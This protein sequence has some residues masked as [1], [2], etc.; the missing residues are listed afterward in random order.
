V[1]SLLAK[2]GRDTLLQVPG[3]ADRNDRVVLNAHKGI[4]IPVRNLD[5]AIIALKVRHDVG[6]NGPKY[7]WVSSKNMSCGNVVHVPLGVSVPIATARLRVC[8]ISRKKALFSRGFRGGTPAFGTD[9]KRRRVEVGRR[10][11]LERRADHLGARCQR[12]AAGR[13]AAPADG[14]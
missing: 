7:T 12:L 13:T 6:H 4:I 14:R 5:G 2:Y 9:S 8:S 3:F 1:D 10:D 11:R